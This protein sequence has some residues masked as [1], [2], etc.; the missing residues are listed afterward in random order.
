MYQQN[1]SSES[2]RSSDRPSNQ[3]RRVLEAAKLAYANKTNESITSQKRGSQDFWQIAKSVLNKAKSAIFP[4][5][6]SPEILSSLYKANLYAKNF[7]KNSNPDDSSISLPIF[8]SRT[9][10]KLHSISVTLKIVKKVM[11]KFHSSKVSGSDCILVMVLKNCEPELSYIPAEVFST[12]LMESSFWDS[13]KVLL[14]APVF[15][16]VGGKVLKNS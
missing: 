14:V 13:W 7:S 12:C 6:N 1:K 5:F 15:K 11:T 4:L 3:F 16:N 10:V 8:L 9:N 2:K